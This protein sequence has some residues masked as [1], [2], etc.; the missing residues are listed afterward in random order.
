MKISIFL[1]ALTCGVLLPSCQSIKVKAAPAVTEQEP[2]S[3]VSFGTGWPIE[4]GFVVTN[5]HVVEGHTEILWRDP[6]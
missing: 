3:V 1:L 2:A 5:H 6:Q 4:Q